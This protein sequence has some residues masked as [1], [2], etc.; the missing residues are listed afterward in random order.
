MRLRPIFAGR[1]ANEE[2]YILY[3]EET[4]DDLQYTPRG[5]STKEV[6]PA[7]EYHLK[8]PNGEVHALAPG[9]QLFT[10]EDQDRGFIHLKIVSGVWT[11]ELNGTRRDFLEAEVIDRNDP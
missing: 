10:W 1:D 2:L 6:K 7:E 3:E 11:G 5:H 9:S 4:Y 8:L